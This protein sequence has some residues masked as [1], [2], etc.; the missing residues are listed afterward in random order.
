M[1]K[2]KKKNNNNNN[3][4]IEPKYKNVICN[5]TKENYKFTKYKH[6]NGRVLE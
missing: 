5:L 1:K 3:K 2:I 6:C 4:I